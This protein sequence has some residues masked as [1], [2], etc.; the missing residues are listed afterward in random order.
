MVRVVVEQRE[1]RHVVAEVARL[2]SD[3]ATVEQTVRLLLD[4]ER[5]ELPH[6]VRKRNLGIH[7]IERTVIGEGIPAVVDGIA[8]DR[9]NLPAR[10]RS[11]T[12][13]GRRRSGRVRRCSAAIAVRRVRP[14]PNRPVGPRSTRS[15]SDTCCSHPNR[16]RTD[17][18][19]IHACRGRGSRPTFDDDV[20][21]R[22]HAVYTGDRILVI[23]RDLVALI[24]LRYVADRGPHATVGFRFDQLLLH[25]QVAR[26][27]AGKTLTNPRRRFGIGILG[28]ELLVDDLGLRILMVALT[29]GCE[30]F[31]RF[32]TRR[33]V[34]RLR[35][36]G[37]ERDRARIVLTHRGLASFVECLPVVTRYGLGSRCRGRNRIRLTRRRNIDRLRLVLLRGDLDLRALNLRGNV[38]RA[39]RLLSGRKRRLCDFRLASGRL[40]QP[41]RDSAVVGL[42]QYLDRHRRDQAHRQFVSTR[43]AAFDGYALDRTQ[44]AREVLVLLIELRGQ[45]RSA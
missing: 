40:R 18:W 1:R 8:A 22:E 5:R 25:R 16:S 28:E 33:D 26:Q 27:K 29:R 6:S 14:P 44:I 7:A 36:L 17:R 39:D 45:R 11:C 43:A 38:R 20:G 35:S 34:R 37:E 13:S 31:E 23:H 42:R 24:E 21:I 12:V 32:L 19:S 15:T 9:A 10:R 4:V 30:H 3:R 41:K 2:H